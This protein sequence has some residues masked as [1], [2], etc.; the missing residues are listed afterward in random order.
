VNLNPKCR[1]PNCECQ[2]EKNEPC[3]YEDPDFYINKVRKQNESSVDT[4]LDNDEILQDA[5]KQC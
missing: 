5:L 1:W 4:T 2:T 3:K